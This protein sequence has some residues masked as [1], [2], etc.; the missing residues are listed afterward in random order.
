M[1][2]ILEAMWEAKVSVTAFM[3]DHLRVLATAR[4]GHH[5]PRLGVKKAS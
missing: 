5:R 4:I 1:E 3:V 2:V